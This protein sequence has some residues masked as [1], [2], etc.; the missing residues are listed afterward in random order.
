[1]SHDEEWFDD[2][3]GP[4]VRP[5]AVTGGRTRPTNRALELV[6]LV[7]TTPNGRLMGATL[8]VEQRSIALLCQ[9]VQSIVEIS[10]RLDLPLGVVRVL[11]GDMLDAGLVT[12]NRPG[13][14]SDRPSAALIEKVLDGLQA[15]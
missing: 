6:A 2:D 11:V 12:V 4:V 13:R 5:Y 7:T 10:A 1:M 9:R 8:E 15:L 14:S 3:A